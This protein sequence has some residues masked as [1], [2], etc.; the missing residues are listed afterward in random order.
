MFQNFEHEIKTNIFRFVKIPINLILTCRNWSIIGKD[1]YAKS[2]WLILHYGRAHALFHAVRLGPTFIDVSVCQ[3]L[4]SR[5]VILS[6]YFTQRLLMNFGKYDQ[7]LIEHKIEHN[8]GQLDADKI[9]AFQQKIK[10]PWASNSP[11]FRRIQT[12]SE[13]CQ[14]YT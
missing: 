7:K 9:R 8:V 5:K 13:R 6:R 10:S 3:T 11:I 12:I 1:P 4:I 2:E 14:R